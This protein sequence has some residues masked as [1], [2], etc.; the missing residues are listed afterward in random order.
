MATFRERLSHALRWTG[1]DREDSPA[2]PRYDAWLHFGNADVCNL[3]CSYCISDSPGFPAPKTLGGK[4]APIDI[5]RL[6][7]TL[8]ASNRT[9][10]IVFAGG[11]EPFLIPNLVDA[12]EALARDHYVAV[13]TNL[14]IPEAI[15]EFARRI[16]PRRVLYSIASFHVEELERTGFTERFFASLHLLRHAGFPVKA[17]MVVHPAVF[18]RAGR[19]R[20]EF[21]RR[22]FDL[23]L[24][25][26]LGSH[27][28]KTYPGAYTAQERRDFEFG[29][30]SIYR[31]KGRLCNAGFNVGMVLPNGEI[32]FCNDVE[33]KVGN[34]YE[35]IRFIDEPKPCREAIR[36]NDE[37]VSNDAKVSPDIRTP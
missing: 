17:H 12:C 13:H 8:R 9:Y 22:G 11:G 7:A 30:L 10:K 20:K 6:T 15:E 21:A 4:T 34:V 36:R 1:S 19:I 37:V 24:D 18:S 16:D 27:R 23:K 32:Q 31:A 3:R 28:D 25:P 14:T 26:F 29:D 5:E 2:E 33:T 35:E